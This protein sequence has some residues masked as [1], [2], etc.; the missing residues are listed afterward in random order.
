MS[1]FSLTGEP[2]LWGTRLVW[3]AT[4]APSAFELASA[5]STTDTIDVFKMTA[6]DPAGLDVT[7]E[8]VIV[9]MT[10]ELPHD[11][12]PGDSYESSADLDLPYGY[13]HVVLTIDD[14]NNGA[15]YELHVRS[16]DGRLDLK[17]WHSLIA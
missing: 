1:N 10:R 15:A 3:S 9:G 5:G 2:E 17:S 14:T 7:S 12:M 13:Y 11:V 6:H 4:L 16:E 8:P